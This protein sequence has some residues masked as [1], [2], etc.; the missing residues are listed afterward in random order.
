MKKQQQQPYKKALEDLQRVAARLGEKVLDPLPA[1][2]T[3]AMAREMLKH[4]D[5]KR[6]AERCVTSNSNLEPLFLAL[7]PRA[8]M[9]FSSTECEHLVQVTVAVAKLVIEEHKG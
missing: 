3:D 4:D 8:E 9:T 1:S 7:K 5:V 2:R 6:V